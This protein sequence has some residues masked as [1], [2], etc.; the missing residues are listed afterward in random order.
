MVLR[1]KCTAVPPLPS[2]LTL[3]S[4]QQV[5]EPMLPGI[6]ASASIQKRM[7]YTQLQ[8]CSVFSVHTSHEV[9]ESVLNTVKCCILAITR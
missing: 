2:L 8:F 3:T 5:R 4:K 1:S 9:T 6:Q 7:L